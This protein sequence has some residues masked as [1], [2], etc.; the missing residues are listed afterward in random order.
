MENQVK[1]NWTPLV[2]AVGGIIAGDWLARNRIT[3]SKK[4]R[5]EI[6]YPEDTE[7][8][9]EEIGE[10]LN[11][12]EPEVDCETEED[13]MQDLAIYLDRNTEWE[14]EVQPH[15]PEGKPDILVG[16]LLALELK[17][18]LS[19]NERNRCIGQCAGY[20]RLWITWMIIINTSSSKIGRLEELLSDKG[21]EQIE[22]WSFS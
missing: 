15:T 7:E 1:Q 8:I 10:L 17:T 12:W 18:D 11:Q 9:Y 2:W 16:D 22:V 21:L 13:Y 4:S 5:A 6:D 20:S 14:V 19:K 3:E